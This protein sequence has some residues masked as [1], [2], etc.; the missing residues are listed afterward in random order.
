MRT[1]E[2]TLLL[3]ATLRYCES[4]KQR[5]INKPFHAGER[6]KL[7]FTNITVTA[8][9]RKWYHLPRQSPTLNPYKPAEPTA[10]HSP[11]GPAGEAMQERESGLA[12]VHGP[13][14]CDGF[15]TLDTDRTSAT[16]T[17][18]KRGAALEG[19]M[20]CGPPSLLEKL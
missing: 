7:S 8:S 6:L 10:D 20:R 14:H 11:P 16:G 17:S 5:C 13:Q 1:L 3:E 9:A 19:S 18:D 2:A 4:W 15:Y 12:L